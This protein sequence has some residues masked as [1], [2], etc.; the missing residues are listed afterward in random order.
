MSK[1][2][3]KPTGK[4][5]ARGKTHYCGHPLYDECT[6]FC[7]PSGKGIAV[8]QQHFNP[9]LKYTRWGRIDEKVNIDISA[10]PGLD[11]YVEAHGDFPSEGLYPTVEV[12]KLMW[13]LKMPPLRKHFWET[14]FA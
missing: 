14:K 3:Y 4:G 1:R 8:I 12:R 5:S 9:S 10:A 11:E 7:L 2:Y 13:A 6:L